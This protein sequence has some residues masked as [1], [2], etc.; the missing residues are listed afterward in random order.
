MISTSN[1]IDEVSRKKLPIGIQDFETMRTQGYLYV[2]KTHDISRLVTQGMFYFL[3][4]PRRFGKSL[5][6][7]TLK[8]LFQGKKELFEGLWIAE[9]GDWDWRE[10]PVIVLDFSDIANDTPKHLELDLETRLKRIAKAYQFD[11]EGPFLVSKFSE[12][13]STLCQKTGRPVVVLID[14]YDKPIINHLGKGNEGLHT[15]KA[16]RDILRSFFGVLKSGNVAPA[17]RF[18]L[19]TGI[20]RFTKVSIFSELNNLDDISMNYRY[21]ELLGYTQQEL[22]TRFVGYIEDLAETLECSAD[23]VTATLEHYYNGYRFS[24]HELWVYNPFSIL[25]AFSEKQFRS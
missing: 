11:L 21:A 6:V 2:D 18:I 24:E 22:E 19:L 20:S 16:N 4:R 9:H 5:L 13:I 3:S 17:L 8:C 14:E 25:K 7:S 23:Q 15:A 10:H 12:L 1:E